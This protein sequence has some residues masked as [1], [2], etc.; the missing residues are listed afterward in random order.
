MQGS[1]CSDFTGIVLAGGKGSRMGGLDKG[2]VLFDNKPM[3]E[4]SLAVLTPYVERSLISANRNQVKY[5]NYASVIS[6]ELPDFQGPLSGILSTLKQ[7]KTPFAIILPCDM[8]YLNNQVIK[9]LIKQFKQQQSDICIVDDTQ[10]VQPIVM[11]LKTSLKDDLA[12]FLEGGG[13]KLRTWQA[14][15]KLDTVKITHSN[16]FTNINKKP[17]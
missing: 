13:R 14:R 3:V 10:R 15:H 17:E 11:A 8:P 5:Q 9:L 4:Y 7:V 6:D 1:G 16:W 12:K 2:L